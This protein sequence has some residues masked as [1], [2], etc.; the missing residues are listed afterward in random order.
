MFARMDQPILSLLVVQDNVDLVA[1]RDT[2][3][4]IVIKRCVRLHQAFVQMEVLVNFQARILFIAAAVLP[5]AR[6]PTVKLPPVLLTLPFVKTMESVA[7]V[8][9]QAH[10]IPALVNLDSLAHNV[11]TFLTTLLGR[12]MQVNPMITFIPISVRKLA[13][14]LTFITLNRTLSINFRL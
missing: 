11:E 8:T 14:K 13:M 7:T 5:E 2:L 9:V 3:E 10:I 6:A 4:P 12:L 1:M